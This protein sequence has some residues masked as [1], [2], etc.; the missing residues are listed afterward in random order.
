M[1]RRASVLR[2]ISPF[3]L[4][5]K[6]RDGTAIYVRPVDATG[7]VF[8]DVVPRR[9]FVE[10]RTC[11]MVRRYFI[12]IDG[13]QHKTSYLLEIVVSSTRPMLLVLPWV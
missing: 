8:C 11:D 3:E 13:K 5:W 7:A 12:T 1:R 4:T 2:T 6:K 10:W 9:T